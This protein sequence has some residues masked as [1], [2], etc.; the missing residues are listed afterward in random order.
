MLKLEAS[1]G[2][3]TMGLVELAVLVD[4]IARWV[5]VWVLRAIGG[6]EL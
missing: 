3:M 4:I 5:V 6:L 2:V 1:I